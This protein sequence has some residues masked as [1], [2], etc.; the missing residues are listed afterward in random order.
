MQGFQI[1]RLRFFPKLISSLPNMRDNSLVPSFVLF[2][3]SPSLTVVIDIHKIK[4]I[5]YNI[6]DDCFECYFV[7]IS[8]AQAFIEMPLI[9]ARM[10]TGTVNP[11][12]TLLSFVLIE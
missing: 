5:Q 10:G 11:I 7:D 12:Y 4:A 2:S 9:A 3:L 1:F 6:L 8:G